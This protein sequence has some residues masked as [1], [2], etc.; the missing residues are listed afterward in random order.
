MH[1]EN[2]VIEINTCDFCLIRGL[3]TKLKVTK[4]E[5]RPLGV[6]WNVARHLE[7]CLILYTM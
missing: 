6:E 4:P 1:V 3:L 7:N 5:P 2:W